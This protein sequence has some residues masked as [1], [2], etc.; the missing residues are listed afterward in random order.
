MCPESR[1]PDDHPLRGIE[2]LC[3]PAHE[4]T[5]DFETALATGS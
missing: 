4:S 2:A 3:G 5:I 1:V